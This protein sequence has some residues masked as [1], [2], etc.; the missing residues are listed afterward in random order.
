MREYRKKWKRG[1]VGWKN[2]GNGRVE[3]WKNGSGMLSVSIIASL[4]RFYSPMLPTL[5]S[6]TRDSV[7]V[8]LDDRRQV[9]Y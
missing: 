7:L 2:G 5:P 9:L 3:G 8:N 6:L 4:L 1:R